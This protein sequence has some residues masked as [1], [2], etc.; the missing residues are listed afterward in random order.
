[1]GTL[2]KFKDLREYQIPLINVGDPWP[3]VTSILS[4]IA[5]PALAPWYGKMEREAALQTALEL[6]TQPGLSHDRDTFFVAFQEQLKITKAAQKFTQEAADIG[7][8]L[9]A[10]VEMDLKAELGLGQALDIDRLDPAMETPFLHYLEWRRQHRVKPVVM[11]QIV[12]SQTHHYAGTMDIVADVD[13]SRL[14][15]DI[16]T[17]KAIYPEMPLQV[18]AYREAWAEMGNPT[19]GAMLLRL[20]KIGGD[21]DFEAVPVTDPALFDVFLHALQLFNWWKEV[22]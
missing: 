5:K 2:R 16:K 14:V 3:S 12:Y 18:T 7:K 20:P 15:I 19:D 8:T 10:L 22:A 21:P 9:H 6:L 13:G 4:V 1:M 17:S 11:E